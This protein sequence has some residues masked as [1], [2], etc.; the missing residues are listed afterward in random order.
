MKVHDLG[1]SLRVL[2]QIE[3]EFRSVGFKEFL[4]LSVNVFS[5]PGGYIQ[6]WSRN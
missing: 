4:Y 6:A 5:C 1:G 2:I 3:F